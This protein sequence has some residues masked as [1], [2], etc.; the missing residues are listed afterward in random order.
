MTRTNA[1]RRSISAAALLALALAASGL[2]SIPANAA[3]PDSTASTATL[4][5]ALVGFDAEVANAHGHRIVTL[6]DG[7][8]ASVPADK[9]EAATKGTYVPQQGVLKKGTS[10]STNS[11]GQ[12]T[13]DCGTSWVGLDPRGGGRAVLTTG[14]TLVHDSGGPWDIHWHV[15][16]ADNGGY[17][18][19]NYDEYD[20]YY[21]G[22]G[23]GWAAKART[24]NLTRGWANATVTWGSF[25]ITANGWL[26]YS[27]SP[28]TSTTIT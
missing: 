10:F 28:T 8:Q 17:S 9:A 16:I 21:S 12:A 18:T 11:Y 7:S 20:G 15:E 13:G 23:L 6:P 24:L 25:T 5:M 4:G 27:Y 26:C 3:A 2:T 14:M 19:Q 1:R 22:L